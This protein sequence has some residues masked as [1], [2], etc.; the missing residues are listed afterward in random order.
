MALQLR[1]L[2]ARITPPWLRPNTTKPTRGF[3]V[4]YAI[5]M[6]ADGM[7]E[8]ATQAL[9]ARMPGE[10]TPTALPY[11]A[12]DR[13]IRRG[14]AETDAA[15]AVRLTGYRRDW[16]VA[17]NPFALMRQ[18]QGYLSP[19]PARMAVVNTHGTWYTLEADG[20]TWS[21]DR[22][23]GNWDWDSTTGGDPA[24]WARFWLIIYSPAGVPFDRDG[25]WDDGEV[26]GD[27]TDSTW[28]SNATPTQVADIRQIVKTWKS[29]HEI[30]ANIVIVFDDNDDAFEPAGAA[31]PNP[32]GTWGNDSINDAGTQVPARSA[33]AIYWD[34]VS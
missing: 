11:L 23:Q 9:Q 15:F 22:A 33:D 10:G 14:W 32:D 6:I 21:V 3:R 19:L 25:T 12:R 8:A 34:G 5:G 31:P 29:A 27:A 17:G 30:C 13:R 16:R 24:M 18:V 4:L 1:D 2:I 7:V 26:W 28:G 20:V